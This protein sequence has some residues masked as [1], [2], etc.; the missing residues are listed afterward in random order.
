MR[1]PSRTN[2]HTLYAWLR[3]LVVVAVVMLAVE[4]FVV[5]GLVMPTRIE[6]SSM[7]PVLVGPHAEVTCPGCRWTF[8]VA[9]DDLPAA[10]P[11]WC[12]DCGERFAD[13]A[14]KVQP[15]ERMWVNRVRLTMASPE[16]YEM[17]VARSP[18]KATSYC[19]KRVLGLPGEHVDFDGGD[20][21]IDGRVVCKTLD[22]Q[23][24]LRQLVHRERDELQLWQGEGPS[25]WQWNGGAWRHVRRTNRLAF[26]PAGG[27]A[28]TDELGVNQT[29]AATAH[30]V[31][32]LMV[33]CEAK[34]APKASLTFV[35][36]FPNGQTVERTVDGPR[37][38]SA[39]WSLWDRQ[40]MLAIDG[41]VAWSD[42]QPRRWSG[43]PRLLLVA[44]G[45]VEIR[46]LNVW[47]DVYYFTRPVDRWPAEGVA[48]GEE[49]Y[50]VVGDN[51]AVSDDCRSWPGRALPEELLVGVPISVK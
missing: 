27:R 47:R 4:T 15:G 20:L 38:F 39:V 22:E 3:T 49:A 36:E 28:V 37:T 1:I 35:A 32:D 7:A 31:T 16:R 45:D 50:F 8:A 29:V 25:D 51:Q 34:L 30:D 18:R 12:S 43:P 21:V 44:V 2:R 17:V 33:T 23:L 10:R 26:V 24:R 42:P 46:D 40:A 19:I 14:K 5:M 41:E 6:G 13:K 48:L 9:A 11:F